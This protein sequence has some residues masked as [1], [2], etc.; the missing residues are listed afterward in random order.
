M[1]TIKHIALRANVAP[2]TVSR[3]LSGDSSLSVSK[4]TRANIEKIAAELGYLSPRQKKL[5]KKQKRPTFA[6]R[7]HHQLSSDCPLSLAV[8]HFLTPYEELSDPYFTSIRIG[9]E[10]CCHQHNIALRNTFKSNIESNKHFLTQAQAVICIGHFSEDESQLLYQLNPKLIFIDSNPFFGQADSVQFNREGAA[11]EIV[12]HIIG[13][14][15]QR[16]AFIGNNETRL[17]VFRQLT[18]AEGIYQ[19]DLCK[20][21]SNFCIESGYQAMSELL[22]SDATYPDVV[23]A[24]TDIIAIGVYRAIQE[25]GLQ[26]PND[27]KVVGMN[28]NPTSQH[29]NPS[30]STMRLYPSNMGEAAV[31]LFLELCSG[32]SYSKDVYLGYDF[33]WRD[34]F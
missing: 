25:R 14:G 10:N 13:K 9:I 17:H 32:R 28:D 34:S 11:K 30:L 24:S 27:I 2:S 1:A 21:S 12:M 16:P 18:K 15:A 7:D 29:L 26:I 33:I 19:E 4:A 31:D 23:F 3:V 8:V 6:A 5:A 20:V 22:S